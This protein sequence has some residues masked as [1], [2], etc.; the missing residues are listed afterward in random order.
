MPESATLRHAS[1]DGWVALGV[2][3]ADGEPEG[4]H[5]L[6]LD[7]KS[8]SPMNEKN[9]EQALTPVTCS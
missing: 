2:P 1:V 3:V 6:R 8:E 4:K 5:M 7:N 9:K